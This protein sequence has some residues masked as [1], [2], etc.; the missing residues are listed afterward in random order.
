MTMRLAVRD[1][2]V[3]FQGLQALRGVGFEL[4]QGELTALIGPNGAGKSTLINVISGELRPTAGAVLLD[5]R[6]ISGL[7]AHAISRI[8]VARTFQGLELFGSL[9]ARD[10][11]VAGSVQRA[12]LGFWRNLVRPPRGAATRRLEAAAQDALDLVGLG[13]RA[14]DPAHIL[15]AG[16]QRLLAIARVLATD[17]RWLILDEPGAGLNDV[18]KRALARVIR[19]LRRRGWTILFVDHDMALVGDLAERLLVLDRGELIADGTADRVRAEPRVVS[20]YLGVKPRRSS[21][22]AAAPIRPPALL[23]AQ[24]LSIG[25]GGVQA[26]DRVSMRVGAG[27]LVA[28]IGANGAGK[29]TLLKALTG[30]VVPAAGTIHLDRAVLAGVRT[31]ERVRRGLSLVPEGRELFGSLTVQEN[32]MVGA[33]SRV[34]RWAR[35]LPLGGL[36]ATSDIARA[37]ERPYGLFPR[38]AE[39]R[40]QLAGSLSG[41]EGQMLAIGRALMNQPLLLMLDEPSL[42]LAPQVIEEILDALLTL[43]RDGLALLLVEQNARTALE[44]ADYA[45]VLETGRLVAEG[46]GAQ[47]LEAGAI[48]EAYFGFDRRTDPAAAAGHLPQPAHDLQ[49]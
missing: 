5:D 11:V 36:A 40:H 1:V 31:A 25:Y 33:Y 15:P 16:E 35:S 4:R 38:L 32:L 10:N 44:I 45:Y 42:G 21:M 14:D 43:R 37:L 9:S 22:R 18:E 29:S 34:P 13:H 28:V 2:S 49:S 6:E 48:A 17:G 26:L 23:E 19:E 41:G 39:R 30:V 27:E 24:G 20:A 8:G 3:R 7:P 46:R 12:G 47:L